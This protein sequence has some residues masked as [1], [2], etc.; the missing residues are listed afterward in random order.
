MFNF[1]ALSILFVFFVT[2]LF[3]QVAQAPFSGG[4]GSRC[5]S[6]VQTKFGM[7][8]GEV[9][10]LQKILNKDS[11]TAVS[12]SGIGSAGQETDYFGPKT[13][14]AVIRFQNKYRAEVLFPAGL[15]AGTG[16]VGVF[17][18]QKLNQMCDSVANSYFE[19]Y[20]EVNT[21]STVTI[22]VNKVPETDIYATDRIIES[23]RED[24]KNTVNTA[25]IKG[26]APNLDL[27]EH[28]DRLGKVLITS[29]SANV[30]SP[31]AKI[32]VSGRGFG[33]INTVYFGGRV[34]VAN[35]KGRPEILEVTIPRDIAYGRYDIAVQNSSGISNTA[36]LVVKD[37]QSTS[38]S[39]EGIEP[40]VVKYGETVT[41]SGQGFT[42]TNNQLDTTFGN[43]KGVASSDG[44]TITFTFAPEHLEVIAKSKA[45]HEYPVQVIVVNDFGVSL[46]TM[47]KL[48]L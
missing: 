43:I 2:P 15:T 25:I 23:I 32:Y 45:N 26:K 13:H 18:L 40:A 38:P 17:T 42:P 22:P 5:I 33:L 21:T 31:G 12:V 47:F 14:D 28:T 48:S 35:V 24:I 1:V 6:G 37:P 36:Y 30:V 8:S 29:L 20:S 16:N 34:P 7:T 44:R 39:V 10:L 9:R 4:T 41:F 3:A 11:E 27:E 19:P 46:P